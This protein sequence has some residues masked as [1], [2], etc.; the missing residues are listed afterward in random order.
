M[1]RMVFDDSIDSLHRSSLDSLP[2]SAAVIRK[3]TYA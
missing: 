2:E 3:G 1:N